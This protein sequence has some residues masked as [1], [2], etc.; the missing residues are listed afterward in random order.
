MQ[1]LQASFKE[2]VKNIYHMADIHIRLNND[3]H[4]EYRE[5]FIKFYN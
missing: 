4:E 5:V 1:T 2:N 3:R